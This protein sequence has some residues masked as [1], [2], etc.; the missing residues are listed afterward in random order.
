MVNEDVL[1]SVVPEHD[2]NGIEQRTENVLGLSG[3]ELVFFL[4]ICLRLCL[5]LE[6][7]SQY[8]DVLASAEQSIHSAKSF[9]AS[10]LTPPE[11]G[12]GLHKDLGG[13]TAGTD[14]PN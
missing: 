11:T 8:R 14:G 4:V 2:V 9:G 5:L 13:N 3:T 10:H 6:A 12:L 7:Y 1:D